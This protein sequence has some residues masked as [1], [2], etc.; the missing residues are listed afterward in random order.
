MFLVWFCENNFDSWFETTELFFEVTQRD[1]FYYSFFLIQLFDGLLVLN[2]EKKYW[3][4]SQKQIDFYG[5]TLKKVT[6]AIKH[7]TLESF[8]GFFS[9]PLKVR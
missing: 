1:N 8:G 9:K 6:Q 5:M 4:L 2:L 3:N 7:A